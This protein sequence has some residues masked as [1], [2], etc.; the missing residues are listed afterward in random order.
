[1]PSPKI[2]SVGLWVKEGFDGLKISSLEQAI[3]ARFCGQV[4]FPANDGCLD[5]PTSSRIPSQ[6]RPKTQPVQSIEARKKKGCAQCNSTS[7]T[8]QALHRID[9]RCLRKKKCAAQKERRCA[10]LLLYLHCR[11]AE[12]K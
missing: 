2:Q 8:S 7:L 6:S 1:M 5:G 12:E 10:Q 4:F 3:R 11:L 9:Q